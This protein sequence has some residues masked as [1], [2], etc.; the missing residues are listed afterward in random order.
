MSDPIIKHVSQTRDTNC[1]SACLAMIAN[2][3]IDIVDA[4]F[5]DDYHNQL[6]E[7]HD[8]LD[9]IGIPYR[10]CFT[11]E[12]EAKNNHIYFMVVPSANIQGNLH[13]IVVHVVDENNTYVYD[14]NDGKAGKVSLSFFNKDEDAPDG[15]R[16]IK[17]WAIDFEFKAEDVARMYA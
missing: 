9:K 17:A 3:P 1:V 8:Y 14:P 7:T 4:E 12:R 5:N 2:L 10:R 11:S 16:N 6:I 13:L 15:Y